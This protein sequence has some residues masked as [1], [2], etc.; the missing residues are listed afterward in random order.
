MPPDL[1]ALPSFLALLYM[2]DLDSGGQLKE[3]RAR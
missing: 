2:T 1:A 3:I